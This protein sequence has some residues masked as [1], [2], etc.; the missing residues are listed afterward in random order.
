MVLEPDQE[1]LQD[2]EELEA[3]LIAAQNSEKTP[4][5]EL[6][7]ESPNEIQKSIKVS[8]DP[9]KPSDDLLFEESSQP[10]SP[11]PSAAAAIVRKLDIDSSAS[12]QSYATGDGDE[13]RK[14]GRVV[15]QLPTSATAV[16]SS[17]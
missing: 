3:L 7:S 16:K 13:Q 14:E 1:D 4:R 9:I 11:V 15:T 5:E 8:S 2:A 6:Q 10:D 12:E 17:T